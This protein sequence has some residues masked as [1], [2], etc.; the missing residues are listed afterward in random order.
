[1]GHRAPEPV[2]ST[3]PVRAVLYAAKSTE[4][5]RGS[6][7]DQL[8]DCRKKAEAEGR[9]VDAEYADEAWSAYSGNRGPEL[10]RAREH[11][12]R[13]GAEL[14]VQHTDRL[15]R[16]DGKRSRHLVEYVLWSWKTG[17]SLRSV[18]DD[19]ACQDLLYA[20]VNGQR[21]Y[22]DSARKSAA[23]QAGLQ[24]RKERGAPVG[25]VPLGYTVDHRVVDD[26][27]AT[28]RVIDSATVGTVKRI[29]DLVESGSTYGD[30]ARTLNA[31]GVTGRRGRPWSQQTVMALIHNTAY[32]GEKGYDVIVDP[33]RFDRVHEGLERLDPAQV[34]KR[35]GGR[36]PADESYLLR[37]IAFCLRCGGRLYT[38]RRAAGRMY[39]CR[40]RRLSNGICSA[41]PVPAELL[42]SHVL[43]HLDSFVGSVESWLA[44]RVEERNVE[45]RERERAAAR[46]RA[47]LVDLERVRDRA[48]GMYR[49]LLD[50]GAST[51]RL[52]LEQ[53]EKIDAEVAEQQQAIRQAE[54]VVSEWTGPPDVDAALDYYTALLDH[55]AGRVRATE[56][57]RE[58]NA[59]LSTIVAGLWCETETDRERLL[60]E[61]ELVDEREYRLFFSGKPI[62]PEFR[63]RPSLPPRYIGDRLEIPPLDD[64]IEPL[65]KLE[66]RPFGRLWR[67]NHSLDLE[68]TRQSADRPILSPSC[69]EPRGEPPPGALFRTRNPRTAR[70]ARAQPRA[71]PPPRPA[72]Q[73]R[74]PRACAGRPRRRRSRAPGWH[75]A[76]R[77]TRPGSR[78]AC[79][80]RAD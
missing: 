1:M 76:P 2:R 74:D 72:G 73:S 30:V 64:W 18:Q 33:E 45:R 58:L 8:A 67:L 37:G 78:A 12:E 19:D 47:E 14:W 25:P 79:A 20:A 15:C 65:T 50:E 46:M 80:S 28:R 35:R 77:R 42:E 44:E 75:G 60:V 7:P 31:E 24:R 61:F 62:P 5:V 39:I 34:A 6:I 70:R 55:V 53:A 36:R 26:Q 51:A 9:T 22:E 68:L 27:I 16:G 4:D 10:A 13:I 23:T 57:A 43:R 48:Y 41:P 66:L 49:E 38:R 71:S 11:A 63:R 29:F 59:A 17:V 3:A 54:V 32:K 21:N 52:A 40:N 56:N 69:L